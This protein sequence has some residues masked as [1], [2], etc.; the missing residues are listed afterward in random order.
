MTDAMTI[1]VRG[2][3]LIFLIGDRPLVFFTT[4]RS[5]NVSHF[6]K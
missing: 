3:I 2:E 1:A 6:L 4:N 5:S